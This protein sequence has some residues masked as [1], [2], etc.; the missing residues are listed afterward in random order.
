MPKNLLIVAVAAGSAVVVPMRTPFLMLA[1]GE[2]HAETH[3]ASAVTRNNEEMNILVK[4]GVRTVR[5]GVNAVDMYQDRTKTGDRSLVYSFEAQSSLG[6]M[7][8]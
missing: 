7:V 2:P 3:A 5:T 4:S 6:R 8:K 1:V